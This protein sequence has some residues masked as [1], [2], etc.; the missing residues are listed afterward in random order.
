RPAP[1]DGSGWASKS[2]GQTK[3]SGGNRGMAGC[4]LS[5][6]DACRPPVKLYSIIR[7]IGNQWNPGCLI[8]LS[9]AKAIFPL[10]FSAFAHLPSLLA[11]RCHK[12]LSKYPWPFGSV[13]SPPFFTQSPILDPL[14]HSSISAARTCL[15]ACAN[16]G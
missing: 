11:D 8:F 7:P 10:P 3:V 12:S 1:A 9:D 14:A 13:N 5:S 2:S 4:L 6:I 15:P 16:N